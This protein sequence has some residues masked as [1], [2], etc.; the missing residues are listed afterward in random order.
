LFWL[1]DINGKNII[2]S[3]SIQIA[4][5][6]LKENSLENK[7]G[8]ICLINYDILVFFEFCD[9]EGTGIIDE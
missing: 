4:F 2:E 5:S 7:I 3:N 1:F 8:S 6:L 9:E